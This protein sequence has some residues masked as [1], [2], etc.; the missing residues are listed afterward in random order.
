MVG[1]CVSWYV[2]VV[3]TQVD[4][5]SIVKCYLTV[6]ISK[7]KIAALFGRKTKKKQLTQSLYYTTEYK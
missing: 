3:D 5:H 4:T 2:R 7:K 1:L 6:C